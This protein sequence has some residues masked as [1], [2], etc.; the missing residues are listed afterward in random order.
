MINTKAVFQKKVHDYVSHALYEFYR[1]RLAR[2][3]HWSSMEK[4]CERELQS[5]FRNLTHTI[6]ISTPQFKQKRNLFNQ[7]VADIRK[8][9]IPYRL[10][11]EKVLVENFRLT[12]KTK[13]TD[14]DSKEFFDQ[15]R[16]KTETCFSE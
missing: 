14:K 9:D 7:I 10:A 15:L 13:L 6:I 2:K 12:V 16:Y 5:I 3:N 11:A 1:G 8:I 4:S